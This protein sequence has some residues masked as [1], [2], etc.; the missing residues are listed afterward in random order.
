MSPMKSATRAFF[1]V[2]GLTSLVLGLVGIAL[3]L[4]PTVPFLLL[5]AYCFA[6]SS[7]RLHRWL[8][9]HPRLG[10]PIGAWGRHGVVSPRAKVLALI[11]LAGSVALAFWGT[12]L[13]WARGGATSAALVVS[14]FLLSRPS[15]TPEGVA[16]AERAPPEA[17]PGR[18][19]PEPCRNPEQRI[20]PSDSGP[21]LGS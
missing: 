1:L 15:R 16:E 8:L 17:P 14:A 3:P 12:D 10:P 6:R 7:E 5:A 21:R 9:E 2:G 4:L 20:P 19:S 18:E 11:S 13:P